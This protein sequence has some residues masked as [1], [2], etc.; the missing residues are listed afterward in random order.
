MNLILITSVIKVSAKPLSYIGFR[1]V[2]NYEDRYN[3]TK[4]TIESIKKYIPNGK[5]FL[6]ECSEL[7]KD[8]EEY[9]RSNVDYFLNLYDQKKCIEMTTSLSKSMG[10]GIMTIKAIK[11]IKE[12]NINYNNLFKISGRYWI[13]DK[14]NYELYNNDQ[15]CIHR[16]QNNFDNVFTCFYKLPKIIVEE[17]YKYLLKPATTNDFENCIG[18]ELIFG[19]FINNLIID[20]IELHKIGI[21]GYV[22]VCKEFI[23]M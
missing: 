12:N 19:K 22:S 2:H 17:W 20:K 10:E 5:I 13:N 6:I 1:S 11:Y 15:I 8:K 4:K 7:E 23:D 16:I 14:F 9:L 21:N 3:D 18:Y